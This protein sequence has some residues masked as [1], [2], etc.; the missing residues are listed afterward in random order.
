MNLNPAKCM[1]MDV[2]FVK[3]PPI[4]LCLK[5]CNQ[6]LKSTAVVEILGLKI[7]KDLKWDTHVS[8]IIKR[9]SGRLFMIS[10]LKRHGL[11]DEDRATIF[12]GFIRTLLE[13]AVPSWH[14]DLTEHQ[15][16]ALE[17]IQKRACR[18]ILGDNYNHYQDALNICFN[19][20]KS[21]FK[22][23]NFREAYFGEDILC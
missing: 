17:R 11:P 18:I 10:I 8:D 7:S 23:N 19:F 5:L 16:T 22:S 14:P 13:Y 9:A 21:L 2:T 6:D 12:I 4:L 20:A 15:H 1:Y 3:N